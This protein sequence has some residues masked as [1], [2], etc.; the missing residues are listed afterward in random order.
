[1]VIYSYMYMIK[2]TANALWITTACIYGLFKIELKTFS[3]L[4]F[5]I[6]TVKAKYT[7]YQY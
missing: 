7:E 2:Q 6:S 4:D 3:A 1:M 5:L